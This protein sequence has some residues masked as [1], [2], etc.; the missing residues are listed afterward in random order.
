L[1]DFSQPIHDS[2][3]VG[4][5][6]LVEAINLH[7]QGI[8]LLHVVLLRSFFHLLIELAEFTVG[9]QLGFALSAMPSCG[10]RKSP[11]RRRL[12]FSIGSNAHKI[13]AVAGLPPA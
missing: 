4:P 3:V 6:L 8:E 5:D 9:F 2:S 11:A 7:A 12:L 10:R 13:A 1:I